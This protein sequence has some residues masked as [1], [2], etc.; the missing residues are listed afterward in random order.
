MHYPSWIPGT[1]YVV[2]L[3]LFIC[4]VRLYRHLQRLHQTKYDAYLKHKADSNKICD[5]KQPPITNFAGNF[6]PSQPSGASS[7]TYNNATGRGK[8]LT[9][10]LIHNVVI[11]CGLP[12]SIVDN[13]NFKRFVSDLDGK[14]VPPCRQTL[15]YSLIPKAAVDKKAALMHVVGDCSSVALTTDTWTDRRCHSYMAVTVHMFMQGR[16]VSHLLAFKAMPGSHTGQRIADELESVVTEFNIKP[17]VQYVVTDNASNMIKALS[18]FFPSDDIE[19]DKELV[20]NAVD[21]HLLW[22]DFAD[23]DDIDMATAEIGT[24]IA[25]FC[26]SLQLVVRDGLQKTTGSRTALA[27]VTKLSS[28]SHHSSSFRSEFEESFGIGRAIPASND[29]RWNSVLRQLKSVVELD[30][31]S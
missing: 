25:C 22:N 16:A 14:Y 1:V 7:S 27:K 24:R 2:L 26:H 17:K 6:N 20:E 15:S 13:P 28:I 23:S 5:K 10:S 4:N 18:L 11:G 8:T 9:E 30:Q 12:L 3:C 21:D 19:G 31:V 29:T